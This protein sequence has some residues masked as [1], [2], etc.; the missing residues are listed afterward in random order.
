MGF[1]SQVYYIPS[2][3]YD[4]TT[5]EPSLKGPRSAKGGG[6]GGY[7]MPGTM[8][9]QAYFSLRGHYHTGGQKGIREHNIWG[10]YRDYI[11]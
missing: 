9:T 7:P 4:A 3:D 2:P 10:L 6:E 11:P 8:G 5:Y 1:K